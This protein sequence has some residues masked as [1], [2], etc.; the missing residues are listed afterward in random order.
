MNARLAFLV[1]VT[2]ASL[3][4]HLVRISFP[5]R[6]VFDE[7]HYATYAT[8]WASGQPTVCIHPPLGTLLYAAALRLS[9]AERYR[10]TEFLRFHVQGGQAGRGELVPERLSSKNGEAFGDFPYVRLRV[11]A[12][13]FGSILPLLSFLVL[14]RLTQNRYAPYLA[15]IFVLLENALLM[16][17]RLIL[18]DGMYLS[19]GM[20]A[21][22]L[23]FQEPRRPLL[24]GIL[25]GLALGV[26]L[27]AIAFVGP[28]LSSLFTSSRGGKDRWEAARACVRF[29]GAGFLTLAIVML[30]INVIVP[31]EKRLEYYETHRP[32]ARGLPRWIGE[33]SPWMRT[34]LESVD[35]LI[36]EFNYSV[37]GYTTAALIHP[38]DSFWYQWP[39][40]RGSFVYY[41]PPENSRALYKDEIWKAPRPALALIGNPIVWYSGTLAA[42]AAILVAIRKWPERRSETVRP[43]V[44]LA[45]GYL[46]TFAP[47]VLFVWRS[48]FLYHY[49]PALLFS[50][51][52][53]A[54]MAGWWLDGIA[55]ERTRVVVGGGIVGLVAAGFATVLSYS[56]G[57]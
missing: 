34:P 16:E 48:S 7:R 19:V 51:L 49:F 3:G 24:A 20:A 55:S 12:S 17:T 29:V 9:P 1:A 15:A 53:A 30:S 44:I 31:A 10:E 32:A 37:D 46:L 23:W 38:A 14:A 6:P 13:C 39:L 4:L 56:L 18:L 41:P 52:A 28:V 50:I 33:T 47:F 11:L 36:Q 25:F 5:D 40:M 43:F 57:L 35:A 54:L 42:F 2:A 26:K 22:V 45:G 8:S 27:L 21:L